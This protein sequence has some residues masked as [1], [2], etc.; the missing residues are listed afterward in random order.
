MANVYFHI[1]KS[2]VNDAGHHPITNWALWEPENLP[3]DDER[4]V[5]R[6]ANNLDASGN[7]AT[8]EPFFQYIPGNNGAALIGPPASYFDQAGNPVTLSEQH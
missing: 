4:F 5:W 7:P 8:E 6:Q 1:D 2:F 3:P